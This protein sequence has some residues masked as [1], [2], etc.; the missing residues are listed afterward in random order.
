MSLTRVV[1]CS[2]R[3]GQIKGRMRRGAVIL[4]VV[5]LAAGGAVLT[6]GSALAGVG[7]QPGNLTLS[8]SS[9]AL[10]LTPTWST[11]TGCPAGFQASAEMSDY[12]TG[13]TLI[14]RISPAVSSGLTAG[15][16][17]TLDGSMQLLLN[18]AGIAST[19]GTVEFVIGCYNQAG[20]TGTASFTQSTFV[21]VP[22]GGGTFTTSATGPVV[23]ATTTTLT[24]APSPAATGGT[25]T[26]TANVSAADS[27][28][29]AGTVQFE[30]GG[31]SIGSPVAVNS[32]GVATAATQATTFASAGTEALSA[33]FTPASA[34]TYSGST[35]T[36]SLLVQTAGSLPATGSPVPIT[37]TITPSGALSVSVVN[38]A[39]PL[40]LNAA[41]TQATGTLGNVTVSDSRNSFPGWSVSGQEAN[42]AGSGTAAGAS[43]P[44][45]DL[46]WAPAFVAPSP[47]GGA[48]LGKMVNPAAPG[49]GSTP[50]TLGFAAAGCGFGT[51][52]MN[53]ALTL[54]IP[55]GQVAGSYAGSMTVTY[56]ETQPS[57]VAGCVPIGVGF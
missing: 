8:P 50:G 12:T 44:G 42:F 2:L 27:T 23:V 21:T 35:G 51:N 52:V 25:V 30:V 43:I 20:A 31:T 45:D 54:N 46:G 1:L 34:V 17:G 41:G 14:S 9:G 15:F 57:G 22:A 18:Q 36:F 10:S 16:S 3:T 38:T 28:T 32:G 29:P 7:S 48:V 6:A 37:L 39:V 49:L 11:S 33:V 26:L 13:G 55:N 19:G 24:A 47:V 56:I 53:A 40:T 5:G 4:G